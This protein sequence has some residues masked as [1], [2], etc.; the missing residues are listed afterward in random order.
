MPE[1][2]K[3]SDAKNRPKSKKNLVDKKVQPNIESNWNNNINQ[4][5]LNYSQNVNSNLIT[6]NIAFKKP[7][8]K[9]FVIIA[10]IIF[11]VIIGSVAG[12]ISWYQSPDKIVSDSIVNAIMADSAIYKGTYKVGDDN[13]GAEVEITAS[14][15][16]LSE[17]QIEANIRYFQPDYSSDYRTSNYNKTKEYSFDGKI[18]FDKSQNIYLMASNI[19]DLMSEAKS[20]IINDEFITDP[21]T[22]ELLID[23]FTETIDGNWI[24]I[25]NSDLNKIFGKEFSSYKTCVADSIKKFSEDKKAIS[26]ISQIYKDNRFITIDEDLGKVNGNFGY[27]IDIDEDIAKKF[28]RK[29][30]KTELFKDLNDCSED[31][32]LPYTY[33]NSIDLNISEFSKDETVEVWVNEWSHKLAKISYE[34]DSEWAPST[35][36]LNTDYSKKVEIETP[37]KSISL[38][39]IIDGYNAVQDEIDYQYNLN[40]KYCRYYD[41]DTETYNYDNCQEPIPTPTCDSDSMCIKGSDVSEKLL[42]F[43]SEKILNNKIN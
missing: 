41:G 6:D 14:A 42:N 8:K 3:N 22:V 20:N 36:T 17:G 24:K 25:S 39:D 29:I 30:N 9:M 34:N 5:N 35:L 15:S 11:L 21:E 23:D 12:Y 31:L 7:K 1:D 2:I 27:I 43:I 13:Q 18:L 19:D 38:Q 40:K 4:S 33:N 26:E 37:K 28:E 16:G 32:H 10:I